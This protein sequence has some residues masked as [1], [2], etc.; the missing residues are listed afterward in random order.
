M[1]KKEVGLMNKKPGSVLLQL[2]N[3][4]AGLLCG[5]ALAWGLGTSIAHA[6]YI[7]PFTTTPV[8]QISGAEKEAYL[9]Q[10]SRA[11]FT[12][13]PVQEEPYVA[14]EG[15]QQDMASLKDAGLEKKPKRSFCS[16]TGAAI[17]RAITTGIGIGLLP[18]QKPSGAAIFIC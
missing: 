11:M 18:V 16:C 5:A 6:A 17:F 12:A 3:C 15:W 4:C 13:A 9:D 14:P 2:R 8:M 10:K 1:D 7:N